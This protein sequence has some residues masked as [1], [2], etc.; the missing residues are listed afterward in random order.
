MFQGL[1][2]HLNINSFLKI[3]YYICLQ[4]SVQCKRMV[5]GQP[6]DFIYIQHNATSQFHSA[7]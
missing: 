4:F 2:R 7:M 6:A 1:V 3:D 5:I